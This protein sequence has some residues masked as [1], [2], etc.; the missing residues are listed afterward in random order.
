ME[1]IEA[2]L[3][4]ELWQAPTT[5][6][7]R[8]KLLLGVRDYLGWWDTT[9]WLRFRAVVALQ[10]GDMAAFVRD[11]ERATS[12]WG[13]RSR[14][15]GATLAMWRGLQA[16]LEGRFAEAETHANAILEL[17]GKDRNFVNSW[18]AMQF[19]LARDRGESEGLSLVLESAL[20]ETPGL[21][22]F[23]AGLAV[24]LADM[25]E[26]GS[27][28]S[29]VESFGP[30]L[31]VVQS[32]LAPSIV[33]ALLSEAV[34]RLGDHSRAEQL[35]AML[36]PYRGQLIVVAWGAC[37][38]GAADRYLAMLADTTGDWRQ[39]DELFQAALNLEESVGAVPLATRTRLSWSR[40][41][42][43]RGEG[44]DRQTT[45]GLLQ[46]AGEDA[47]HLGMAGVVGEVSALQ[48]TLER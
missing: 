36:Q 26:L 5:H 18:A 10:G 12:S 47:A 30:D 33:M 15:M 24:V 34:G 39:A 46:R 41:L 31:S 7:A 19:Q 8:M 32:A 2:R 48:E 6:W 38:L 43:A 11:L 4:P 21:V 13:T 25:G 27:T 45:A 20:A 44:A 3:G 14:S 40:C 1:D 16:I 28:C 42:M 29:V 22:V 17:E 9:G 35:Q 23:Q 37:V